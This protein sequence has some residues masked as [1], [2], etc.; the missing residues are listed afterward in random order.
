[1][2]DRNHQAEREAAFQERLQHIIASRV[3]KL[4]T[5]TL[6][7]IRAAAVAAGVPD[8]TRHRLD[9]DSPRPWARGARLSSYL[10]A[11]SSKVRGTSVPSLRHHFD[12]QMVPASR[13]QFP[14]AGRY[15]FD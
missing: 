3:S 2:P 11:I 10:S 12:N 14:P 15:Q 13:N 1:M 4:R 8:P 7:K 5:D 6:A 9:I